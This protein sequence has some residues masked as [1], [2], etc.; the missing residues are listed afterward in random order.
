[1]MPGANGD[2]LAIKYCREIMRM[3][4]IHRERQNRAFV[5]CRSVDFEA[6]DLGKCMGRLYEKILLVSFDFFEGA[7]EFYSGGLALAQIG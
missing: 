3:D 5:R 7:F 4:R 1:M 2:A 6:V